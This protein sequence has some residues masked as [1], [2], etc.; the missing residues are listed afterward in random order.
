M[1][2]APT[3]CTHLASRNFSCSDWPTPRGIARTRASEGVDE[4]TA[5]DRL[6]LAT[7]D[8]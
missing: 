5:L 3:E 7:Q 1:P 4:L 8:C 6:D 2:G